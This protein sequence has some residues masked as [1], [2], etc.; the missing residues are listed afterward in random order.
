V[1]KQLKIGLK[2][3]WK[4][5]YDLTII[6]I[7]PINFIL[8][9]VL[10]NNFSPYSV[11]HISYMV[12]VPYQTTRILRAHGIKADYLSKGKS[13]NWDKSDYSAPQSLIPILQALQE[14]VMFWRIISKYEVIHLHFCHTMS[15]SG[16]E[17]P[18]L[19]NL[20]RKIIIHYR[21]CEIRDYFKN[22][23]LHPGY[24]ICELCD[25]NYFCVSKINKRRIE[26]V[27]KF[28]DS[29]LITTPDLIDFVPSA[30]HIPFFAPEIE[31]IQI[32]L[33]KKSYPEIP[34]RI[35]HWTNHPGI[36]GTEAILKIIESLK[37]KNY[38]IEFMFLT[39]VSQELIFQQLPNFDLTIGKMKMGYYANSQ[40]ESL[41][42]GVPAI[43]WIRPEFVTDEILNSGLIISD[44]ENL[45]I[46][47]EQI[48]K[49]PEELK[50]K[51]DN[52][53]KFI[54]KM[55]NSQDIANLYRKEYFI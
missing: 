7:S 48:L 36:E 34:L 25:Y 11:L 44:L 37:S 20:K 24:N 9:K 30:K 35:L 15:I 6:L 12:H 33:K 13:K 10:R 27:S 29:F 2:K 39:D 38:R 21:G 17:M 23:Q 28:G 41:S 3:S 45:E 55:H 54:L 42:F 5:L 1:K 43:C 31:G 14:F 19:K 47:L 53:R 32:K 22:I 49:N 52:A 40:I 4:H 8:I 26:F 51:K 16:W 46:T 18:I 50:S